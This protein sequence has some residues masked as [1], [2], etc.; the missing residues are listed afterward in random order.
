[1]KVSIGLQWL[2]ERYMSASG[3]FPQSSE[4]KISLQMNSVLNELHHKHF[5]KY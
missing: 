2:S 4:A 3:D 1:M 5:V